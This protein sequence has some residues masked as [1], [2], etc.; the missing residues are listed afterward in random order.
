MG[1]T[2]IITFYE[3]DMDLRAE[4]AAL[5]SRAASEPIDWTIACDGPSAGDVAAVAISRDGLRVRILVHDDPAVLQSRAGHRMA[6]RPL[7]A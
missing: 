2:S 6:P 3:G 1:A 4:A 5:S 7:A